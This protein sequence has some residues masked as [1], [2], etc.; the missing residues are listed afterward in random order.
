MNK[1]LIIALLCLGIVNSMAQNKTV[2][3]KGELRNFQSEVSL[4][5]GTPEAQLLKENIQFKTDEQNKFE[6]NFELDE[7]AY[8]NLGRNTLYLSPGDNLELSLDMDAPLDAVFSGT[9]AEACDYLKERPFPKAGSYLYGTDIM[10][11]DPSAIELGKR[12]AKH[13]KNKQ[14]KLDALNNVSAQFKKM[15]HG[16]ILFDGANTLMSFGYRDAYA[17]KV[18]QEE[19]AQYADSITNLFQSDITSYLAGG[20]DKDYLNI[21]AYLSVSSACIKQLGEDK[22]DAEILDFLKVQELIYLLN[23]KGPIAD[24]L[25]QKNEQEPQLR[26]DKYKGI[27]N[28]AFGKYNKLIPGQK[29]QNFEMTSI[30]G[31]VITLDDLK[32]K[33]LVID[34]WATWCGPCKAESP[35]FEA[36]ADKYQSDKMEFISLSIDSSEKPWK[37]YLAEHAKTSTQYITPRPRL[38]AY[39]LMTVPRF[40]IISDDGLIIDAFAPVPSD[41]AFEAMIQKLIQ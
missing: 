5:K 20:H 25:S 6:L 9:G 39:E 3:L 1:A 30:D 35:H 27:L 38:K 12:V 40:M 2:Q 34:V 24:V 13:I 36:L 17:K 26:T 23:R 7:P 37:K 32:G 15:E 31:K 11:G 16:R 18:P 21:G 4:S 28:Q 33:I 10:E 29:A 14:E 22:M 8:F 41:K 19:M